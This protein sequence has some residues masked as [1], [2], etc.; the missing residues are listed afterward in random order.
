[1]AKTIKQHIPIFVSSTYTDLIPYRKSI[2][3][4]LD[5]LKVGVSGME[6]FGARTAEPLQT[7]IDEVNKSLIFVGI[8]GMRYGSIDE[9]T[10]KSFVQV[11]YET[12][13][14]KNL[15]ILIYLIDEEKAEIAP[16]FVDTGDPA[17]KLQEF[18]DA[19]KKKHTIDTF[20]SPD[21]LAKKVERDLRRLFTERNFEIESD[22]LQPSVQPEQTIKI[23]DK[24]NLMPDKYSGSEIEL[25][26]NFS[27]RPEQVSQGK[28]DALHLRFGR[29]IARRIDIIHPKDV[30]KQFNFLDRLFAEYEGCEFL[31]DSPEDKQVKIVAKL[32]FGEER[33][34]VIQP[35]PYAFAISLGTRAGTIK[36]LKTGEVYDSYIRYIP[37]KAIIYVKTIGGNA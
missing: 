36:D 25:I 2:W 8:V 10:D 26:I 11:E 5:K 23:L 34:E 9:K 15:D 6:I 24:F 19:L 1:M 21:D 29:S 37:R 22:K 20:L 27:G 18:K 28:C 35:N 31:Y 33:T 32:A 13:I 30:H 7:C 17:K 16:K 14:S 3:D 4:A 12:A